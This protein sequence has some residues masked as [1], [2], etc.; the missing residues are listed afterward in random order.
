MIN[1]NYHHGHY[2]HSEQ[3]RKN[4]KDQG[5]IVT[6]ELHGRKLQIELWFL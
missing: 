6:F 5:I 3:I 1:I 2:S 4:N